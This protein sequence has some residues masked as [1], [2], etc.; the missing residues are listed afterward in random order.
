MRS[1][2]VSMIVLAVGLAILSIAFVACAMIERF[3]RVANLLARV[4]V[5]KNGH[6]SLL[7]FRLPQWVSLRSGLNTRST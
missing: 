3:F 7:S 2:G 5:N 1:L 4:D 6:W